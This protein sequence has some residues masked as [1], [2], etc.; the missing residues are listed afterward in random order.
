MNTLCYYFWVLLG[1]VLFLA[2]MLVGAEVDKNIAAL[3]QLADQNDISAQVKLCDYHYH[4]EN[5]TSA[6]LWCKKAA[7]RGSTEASYNLG[8]IYRNAENVEKDI[9]QAVFW[10][11]K[12]A[13]LGHAGAQNNLGV[14]YLQGNGVAQD[15]KQAAKWYEKAATQGNVVAQNN[16][17]VMY[18]SGEGVTKDIQ[19]AIVWY[20]KAAGQ[21][22]VQ[23]SYNL[24]KIYEVEDRVRDYKQAMVWYQKAV[25]KGHARAAYRLGKM[26]E[27]GKGVKKDPVEAYKWMV[28]YDANSRK[29][30]A[31]ELEKRLSSEEILKGQNEAGQ[32]WE[33]RKKQPDK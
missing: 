12:A 6:L 8:W 15:K 21:G 16:L 10:Y 27:D 9:Q 1:G 14:M 33:E 18:A 30:W 17:G 22:S 5:Y 7:E 24:G 20:R 32:W 23:A 4:D 29:N 31:Y 2:E 19:Q 28:I 26:Y 25:K 11:R 13:E 3:E